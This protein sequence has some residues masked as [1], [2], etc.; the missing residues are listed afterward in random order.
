MIKKVIDS[1]KDDL[2]LIIMVGPPGC[3]KSTLA[4]QLIQDNPSYSLISSDAIRDEYRMSPDNIDVFYI[5]H[6]RTV[7]NLVEGNSVIF[8]ATNCKRAHRR[9]I[10][11]LGE[12][13]GA[14][15][16]GLVYTGNIAKCI[17]WNEQRDRVVPDFVIEHMYYDLAYLEPVKISEGFDML[18]SFEDSDDYDGEE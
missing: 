10:I 13:N 6:K 14:T 5:A 17:V 16:I 9:K 7:N 15:I 3:G 12:R 4:H 11:R 18:L 8:D 1:F 2:L